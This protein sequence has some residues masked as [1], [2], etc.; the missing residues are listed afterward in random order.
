MQVARR[1]RVM[2]L[3]MAAGMCA[4]VLAALPQPATAVTATPIGPQTLVAGGWGIGGPASQARFGGRAPMPTVLTDGRIAWAEFDGNAV[5]VRNLDGTVGCLAGCSHSAGFSGD[6]GP[7]VSAQLSGPTAVAAAPDDS[8]YV[9][10]T[11]NG[12]VRRIAADGTITTVA[13]TG[14]TT[15]WT[16]SGSATSVDLQP[17]RLAVGSDGTVFVVD[18][19]RRNVVR[20]LVGSTIS[21][22]VGGVVSVQSTWDDTWNGGS[23]TAVTLDTDTATYGIA[24]APDQSLLIATGFGR[25]VLRAP[26]DGTIASVAGVGGGVGQNLGDGGPATAAVLA[27]P[28]AVA[29]EPDG[30]I[31]VAS[32]DAIRHFTVGGTISTTVSALPGL[33]SLLVASGSFITT[34]LLAPEPDGNAPTVIRST[35]FAGATTVL[36][37]GSPSQV[38][39]GQQL[40]DAWFPNVAD[41]LTLA[42]GTIVVVEGPGLV[43]S[44]APGGVVTTIAGSALGALVFSGE[45]GP[46]T[47]AVLPHPRA[48]ARDSVGNLFVACG[49]GAVREV[50]ASDGT[51]HTVLGTGTAWAGSAPAGPLSGTS[52]PVSV[53][54]SM[55][56]AP[57]GSLWV[58]DGDGGIPWG[59]RVVRL[60]A[61][62]ATQVTG[63]TTVVNGAAAVGHP[64]SDIGT[65][66]AA[67]LATD[68]TMVAVDINGYLYR[69]AADR[70]IT[71]VENLFGGSWDRVR[72]SGPGGLLVS[73]SAGARRL[74]ADGSQDQFPTATATALSSGAGTLTWVEQGQGL[75][76]RVLPDSVLRPVAPVTA[77]GTSTDGFWQALRVS[78]ALPA[79]AVLEGLAYPGA[80]Q[81]RPPVGATQ[82]S[83]APLTPTVLPLTTIAGAQLGGTVSASVRVVDSASHTVSPWTTLTFVWRL[84]HQCVQGPSSRLVVYGATVTAV[85]TVKRGDTASPGLAGTWS[86]APGGL[87]ASR[88]VAT[89]TSST[90]TTAKAFKILRTTSVT[91]TATTVGAVGGCASTTVYSVRGVLKAVPSV[92]SARRGTTVRVTGLLA[93]KIARQYV[94][95]QR[96]V[97]TKW[98]SLARTLTTSTGAAAFS[99]K[100]PATAGYAYYRVVSTSSTALVGGVSPSVRVRA[101]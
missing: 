60:A 3:V 86:A 28:V 67:G 34:G 84:P 90:G 78:S 30:S 66:S 92:T 15:T 75:F 9:S 88:Y 96:L 7:A 59:Y 38:G 80:A 33:S 14:S 47:S 82:V 56:V 53:V 50:L 2:S 77:V 6:G 83:A 81:P 87:A 55:S 23:A 57:D 37:G 61:G 85:A 79:G 29:A 95:L 21:T 91:Y 42:D 17:W 31:D 44:A 11:Y 52:M 35:T 100:L 49:D 27:A 89:A 26:A 46:A 45:G 25:R 16:A 93:P 72:A 32:D 73:G 97:G 54:L 48:L 101:T 12:R 1:G 43:R 18:T 20:K 99:T 39:D 63:A 41:T 10:D 68:G 65:V 24:V 64:I 22:A 70:T 98:I 71:S 4:G 51:I 58:V 94:T 36:V 19:A 8:L 62:T 5:H 76:Q 40:S 13:G 74:F 69:T